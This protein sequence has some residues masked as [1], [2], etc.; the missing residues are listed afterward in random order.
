MPLFTDVS[1]FPDFDEESGIDLQFYAQMLHSAE[2]MQASVQHLDWELSVANSVI[3][4][5][6]DLVV[7]QQLRI[8]AQAVKMGQYKLEAQ[9]AREA[10]VE[11]ET[12]LASTMNKMV[13]GRE[14]QDQLDSA[15]KTKQS[16]KSNRGDVTPEKLG[17][18]LQEVNAQL[19]TGTTKREKAKLKNQS[20]LIDMTEAKQVMKGMDK[21]Q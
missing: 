20:D 12:Q 11:I 15:K 7:A 10:H 17:T 14:V 9:K 16:S 8:N 5:Y 1:Q 6:K 21:D 2:R 3:K 13:I 4:K 18:L 19:S